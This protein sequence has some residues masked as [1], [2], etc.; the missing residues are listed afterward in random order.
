MTAAVGV[1]L[2]QET[3]TQKIF[4][5]KP[6][7][8]GMHTGRAFHNDDITTLTVS[9]DRTLVATGQV[10]SRPVLIVWNSVDLTPV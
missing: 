5:G 2:D 6:V 8:A 7:K 1:V 4:G 10:G 9:R 3:N